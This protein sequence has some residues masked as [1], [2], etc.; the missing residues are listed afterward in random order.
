MPIYLFTCF[1]Y[2]VDV[3]SYNFIN[4]EQKNST[5]AS[6]LAGWSV[7]VL[8][9]TARSIGISW[10]SPSSLLNGGICFYVAHARKTNGSSELMGEILAENITASEIT[11]LDGYMVYAVSVVA[12]DGNMMPFKSAD[13]LVMT[14]EGGE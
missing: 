14:D 7:T 12:V 13:V 10:S 6:L 1:I 3:I 4:F 9:K 5:A 8:N 2:F 11:D